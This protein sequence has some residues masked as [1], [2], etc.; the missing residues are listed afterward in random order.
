ML[1]CVF[2]CEHARARACVF[3]SVHVS[4]FLRVQFCACAL[5]RATRVFC[6]GT[7]LLMQPWMKVK[8]LCG[9]CHA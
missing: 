4:A 1:A 8:V 5:A 3:A 2:V 9:S 7:M 6:G